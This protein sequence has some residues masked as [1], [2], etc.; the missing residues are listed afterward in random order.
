MRILGF[1]GILW[2]IIAGCDRKY[3]GYSKTKTQIYY[4]LH[5]IGEEIKYPKPTDYI[6]VS[7]TYKTITDSVFFSGHRTFQLTLPD[8]PGS[9]D[10]CFMML[11]P[12]DSATFI[13]N[14][15][16]LFK[17]TLETTLPSFI[18]PGSAMKVD[19]KMHDIRTMAEYERD[20]AEFLKWIE[21]FGEYEK[22]VLSRYL[23]ER[24]IRNIDSLQEGLYMLTTRKGNGQKIEKGNIVTIHYE[25]RFL[26][27][28]IFDSTRK[29]NMPLEF[30]YGSEWQ[31]IKGIENALAY[32]EELQKAIIIL[33]SEQAW[34]SK[35]SSTGIIPPFSTLVFELEV[36]KV[37]KRN[38]TVKADSTS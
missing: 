34:G 37:V 26:D 27:G 7:F 1:I 13:I 12:G 29:R 3:P 8:F 24:K 2:I 11:S 17:R 32:M 10:E 30:V 20:K 19:I 38:N 31:V 4:K 33:P 21:D 22:M 9:I 16:S 14:A 36:V 23:T 15:D 35:G 5:S 28:K 18:Q 6:T 25:G